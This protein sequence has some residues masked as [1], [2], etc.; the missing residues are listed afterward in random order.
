[1]KY[2]SYIVIVSY[3][4]FLALSSCQSGYMEEPD[5]HP[6][7]LIK[8]EGI[9]ASRDSACMFDTIILEAKAV[10]ENLTYKWQRAKGSLVPI[11]DDPSKAYFWGCSTCVGRLTVS[12][13]V[14][15]EYGSETK[16]IDVFVW[17]W[18]P[19]QER[20]D[21]WEWRVYRMGGTM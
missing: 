20:P 3:I 18:Y 7:E 12:C 17:P 8:F 5:D 15:N 14:S 9:T 21:Y 10:G 4:L 6:T 1:M 2:L 11:K 19:W 13:T 16:D